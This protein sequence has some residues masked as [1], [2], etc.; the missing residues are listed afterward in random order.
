MESINISK[1][2]ADYFHVSVEEIEQS[3]RKAYQDLNKSY[4][5]D[6]PKENEKQTV[7][8]LLAKANESSTI[9][10]YISSVCNSLRINQVIQTRVFF[11]YTR[12]SMRKKRDQ[13]DLSVL[14]HITKGI[15]AGHALT[16]SLDGFDDTLRKHSKGP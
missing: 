1:G 11:W 12:V 15:L 6:F 3:I 2:L 5:E 14:Y 7:S 4:P 16:N 13:C 10:E 9:E 8:D